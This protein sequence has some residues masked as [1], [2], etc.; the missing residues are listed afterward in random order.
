MEK[1]RVGGKETE[2]AGRQEKKN[3]DGRGIGEEIRVN[4]DNHAPPTPL[5]STIHILYTPSTLHKPSPLTPWTPLPLRITFTTKLSE[6]SPAAPQISSIRHHHHYLRH[7]ISSNNII[8]SSSHFQQHQLHVTF[9]TPLLIL[10]HITTTH[11]QTTTTTTT[12]GSSTSHHHSLYHTVQFTHLSPPTTNDHQPHTQLSPTSTRRANYSRV[13]KL[14]RVVGLLFRIVSWLGFEFLALLL[15][16]GQVIETSHWNFS[17]KLDGWVGNP[18]GV[19]RRFLLF[20]FNQFQR[21]SI[22]LQN[23]LLTLRLKGDPV[24]FPTNFKQVRI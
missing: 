18:F 20:R 11:E 4:D 17:Y 15:D 7:F 1:E 23:H 24:T 22:I 14:V 8:N 16:P 6:L 21:I 12:I 10:P 9:S 13:W 2:R 5:S 19:L 3:R